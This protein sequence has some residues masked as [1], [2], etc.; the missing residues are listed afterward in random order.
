MMTNNNADFLISKSRL[1]LGEGGFFNKK[2]CFA[3]VAGI[4][5]IPLY[6]VFKINQPACI[7][8]G[9]PTQT[10]KHLYEKDILA[11]DSWCPGFVFCGL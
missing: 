4:P 9:I 10:L 8:A 7:N 6:F 11:T 2:Q 3:T 1:H 5:K